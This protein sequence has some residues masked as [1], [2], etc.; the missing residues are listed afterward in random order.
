[1]R[2]YGVE[3]YGSGIPTP[4]VVYLNPRVFVREVFN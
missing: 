4:T 3:D 2:V 1:M